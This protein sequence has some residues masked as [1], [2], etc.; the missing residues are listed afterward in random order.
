MTGVLYRF[1]DLLLGIGKTTAKPIWR[2]RRKKQQLEFDFVSH[3]LFNGWSCECARIYDENECTY[4][5]E[6]NRKRSTISL[7]AV[8]KLSLLNNF[9]LLITYRT[10]SAQRMSDS[11][12]RTKKFKAT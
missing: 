5:P 1:Y 12:F 9:V 2:S 11:W 8:V 10:S 4:K 6:Y 7:P 3:Q